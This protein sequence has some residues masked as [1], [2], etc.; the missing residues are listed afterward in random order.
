M[1]EE[2][3]FNY[4]LSFYLSINLNYTIGIVVLKVGSYFYIRNMN[5]RVASIKIAVASYAR[6]APEVL[7]FAPRA[8]TPTECLE[9]NEVFAL[10][11]IRSNVEFCSHF[12]ILSIASKLTIYVEIDV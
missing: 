8:I 12:S 11:K 2:L 3:V 4:R 10:F 1:V 5:L 6:K 7:V 9:C